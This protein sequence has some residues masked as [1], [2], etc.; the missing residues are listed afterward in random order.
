MRR[1]AMRPGLEARNADKP[2][3]SLDPATPFGLQRTAALPFC[4]HETA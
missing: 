4:V 1:Q 2:G 3:P